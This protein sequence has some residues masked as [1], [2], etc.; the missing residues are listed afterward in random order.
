MTK[1]TT[2]TPQGQW[3]ATSAFPGIL[4]E[5]RA[6]L[7]SMCRM[8]V[9]REGQT[10]VQEEAS[11]D[12]VGCVLSGILRMQKTLAD[13]RHHIVGLLVEGDIFG[14]VF[15]GAVE[16]AIEAATDVEFC[17]FPRGEFEKLLM[18]SP[19]L[20][21]AVMLNMLNELDRARDWMII[22]SNQKITSRVAGFLLLMIS[23]FSAIDHILE[24][25]DSGIEI[26]IPI[27]R[28]D[29]SHFLGTRPESI[30]RALH[31]LQDDGDIRI[32]EPNVI[33]V[34]DF[35]A[36]A[37]KAGEDEIDGTRSL[38]EILNV[39]RQVR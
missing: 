22:L 11:T 28:E 6:S 35:N 31:A 24:A 9:C 27:S 29:L 3:A 32:V 16:F 33:R 39:T 17:A 10:V 26:R 25:S 14:R 2:R 1:G 37:R 18:R 5:T 23:R 12:F 30:S 19:D 38:R 7:E 34:L 8:R 13:G 21:R 20:D 15:G 36:L 4:P